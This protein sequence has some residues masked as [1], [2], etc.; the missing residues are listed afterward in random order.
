MAFAEQT[1]D[2]DQSGDAPRGIGAAAESE[3][4]DIVAVFIVIGNESVS[5]AHISL[6]TDAKG[7]ADESA[8]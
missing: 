8:D 4:V 2:G 7:T 6:Q 3:Q 5:V 1:A